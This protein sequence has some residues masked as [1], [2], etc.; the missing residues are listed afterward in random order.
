MDERE[1]CELFRKLGAPDPEGWARSQV[2]EGI[3]QLA[4]FLFLHKG[5]K[6]VVKHDDPSWI[7]RARQISAGPGGEI[8][9]ALE[10]VLAAG[11]SPK[12]LT[13]IV[14]VMQWELLAGLCELLDDPDVLEPQVKEVAWGLF[15]LDENDRPTEA[16]SCLIESVLELEPNGREMR[17]ESEWPV[18]RPA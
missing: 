8:G 3:P 4:R 7:S 5:W 9:P 17:P 10:R 13:R 1:L 12:D 2:K 18:G 15:Q 11:G 16:I 6:L 14:R